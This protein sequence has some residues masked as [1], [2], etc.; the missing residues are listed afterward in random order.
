MTHQIKGTIPREMIAI[1]RGVWKNTY[2]FKVLWDRLYQVI[3]GSQRT[4]T[5]P[6]EKPERIQNIST[7]PVQTVPTQ[8]LDF[9]QNSPEKG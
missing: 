5:V 4:Q 6:T 7:E 9:P 1:M 3:A 2:H 8:P